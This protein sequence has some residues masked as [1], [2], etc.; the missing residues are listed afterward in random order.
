[1]FTV[2]PYPYNKIRFVNSTC[3]F[4]LI[5]RKRLGSIILTLLILVGLVWLSSAA[6]VLVLPSRIKKVVTLL[7]VS[8]CL[9]ISTVYW[10]ITAQLHC[11]GSALIGLFYSANSQYQLTTRIVTTLF[12]L[13]GVD[14]NRI[15]QTEWLQLYKMQIFDD[16]LSQGPLP[17][18]G[19]GQ[20]DRSL[21]QL[22]LVVWTLVGVSQIQILASAVLTRYVSLSSMSSTVISGCWS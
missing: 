13:L 4:I 6:I 19:W 20:G 7:V 22:F 15:V 3:C 5:N 18:P 11:W 1:M 10:P 16:N 2:H 9:V 14:Q 12:I 17:A 21:T 8:W